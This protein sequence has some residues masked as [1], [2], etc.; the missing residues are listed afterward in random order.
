MRASSAQTRSGSSNNSQ[1]TPSF[2]LKATFTLPSVPE[3]PGSSSA[4]FATPSKSVNPNVSFLKLSCMKPKNIFLVAT[5]VHMPPP[6]P[7]NVALVPF[8]LVNIGAVAA[9]QVSPLSREY[10]NAGATL[11]VNIHIGLLFLVGL[12]G[13]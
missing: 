7:P 11:P 9:R 4:R 2:D 12:A 13:A 5:M 1:F 3:G 8:L 10:L 6:K